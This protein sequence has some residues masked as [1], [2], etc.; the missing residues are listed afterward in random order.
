[1]SR[2]FARNVFYL[3]I[4]VVTI[5]TMSGCGPA[6]TTAAPQATQAQ[7]TQPQQHLPWQ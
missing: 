2:N 5:F 6:A 1:M 7:A 3:I 4:L